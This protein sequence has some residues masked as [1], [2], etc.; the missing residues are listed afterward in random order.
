MDAFKMFKV[1][2]L[3]VMGCLLSCVKD[4]QDI[5]S[6]VTGDPIFGMVAGFGNESVTIEA[7]KNQWTIL[8]S[9]QQEDSA[10]VYS[11]VFSQN[12]CLP[13][14][15][16]SW[17]FRFYQAASTINNP[18]QEF[19]STIVTGDKAYVLSELERDSFRV[20]LTTH[21]GLFMSGYSYWE[22]LNNPNTSF[23][24]EFESTVGYQENINVCFQ[25]LAFT[26][27]QYKQCIYFDPVT[28]IPC[29]AYIEPIFESPRYISLNVRPEGTPPF[30]IRWFNESTASSIVIPV[31]DS[32][33][34]EIYAAVSVTDALG[35]RSD[36]YQTIRIQNGK[37][38]ACYFPIEL[39]S[40]PIN[41]S[42][43]EINAGRVEIIYMDANGV[44][45]KSTGGVQPGE[46]LFTIEQISNYGASH[47]AMTTYIVELQVHAVLFS[48]ASGESRSFETERLTVSL[49]HP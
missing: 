25:S 17:T 1:L 13:D 10:V 32:S 23:F 8:P 26:G 45:W 46:A 41:N 9:I 48:N 39:S 4:P 44:E 24:H 35:N 31:Q 40:I 30:D 7:G 15:S 36:L 37:V 3:V 33:L 42:S 22:D 34:A 19:N 5:P 38:D 2:P 14:C 21:P 49:G 47:L 6:G 29:L 18:L 16:P 12:G 27:C 11:A 43:G 28:E 20:T